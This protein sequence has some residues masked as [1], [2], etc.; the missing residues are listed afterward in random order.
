MLSLGN[1]MTIESSGASRAFER[2]VE[3][4]FGVLPNFFLSAPDSPELIQQLWGYAKAAYLDNPLPSL[5]KERLF[6]YLSRFCGIR[7]CIVRH[8]GF[9]LGLGRPSGD[10]QETS[11][12]AEQVVRLLRRPVPS[13]GEIQRVVLTLSAESLPFSAWP[14]PETKEEELIL[15]AATALFLEP[16][17]SEPVRKALRNAL[18]PVSFD[19]LAVLLCF[20]RTAH[21]WTVL[22]P[23][24][25]F[26]E[27]VEALL[28]DHQQ[29]A[30]L[31][32]H[33]PEACRSDM[34]RRLFD[35]LASF[36]EAASFRNALK[37]SERSK[38][39][40]EE[41]HR[42]KDSFLAVVGH[43]LRNPISAIRSASEVLSLLKI[44]DDRVAE[45]CAL[46]NRQTAA[47]ARIVEDLLD[48]SRVSLAKLPLLRETLDLRLLVGDSVRDH[49]PALEAAG[50]KLF[51]EL[52][53][54]PVLVSADRVRAAQIF[55]N[56]MSNACRFTPAG[57]EVSVRV[58][59]D[60]GTATV[61]VADT[62]IGFS[63]DLAQTLFVPFFQASN[64]QGDGGLGLGLP[65]ARS[66]AELHGGTLTATSPGAN[67]GARFIW[68]IAL[69]TEGESTHED[70]A[71][72]RS[73][74]A[75]P[76]RILGAEDDRDAAETLLE[77]V[78]EL[79]MTYD[80]TSGDEQ[81]DR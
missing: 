15:A 2:E 22:H 51:L 78:S 29:L 10:A 34:S 80:G 50:L 6:V 42:Q 38:Q 43:E 45:V 35:E 46:L 53:D 57:G 30:D 59:A 65:I 71:S 20:I 81:L 16:A 14:P 25:A 1:L 58:L 5:F 76:Q 17:R 21:Y 9:L 47:V 3:S 19:R 55:E 52:P 4:R 68:T 72:A 18:G 49:A 44:E 63:A 28:L 36:R 66:L 60:A 41:L 62:G 37:E 56:L 61:E 73:T 23:E 67:R 7:Y 32:L 33:D 24:L 11:H 69:D 27:D 77:D 40:L 64:A 75:E 39:R 13:A 48:I 26:E 74:A 8:T 79:R 31:L 70:L 12:T 54:A